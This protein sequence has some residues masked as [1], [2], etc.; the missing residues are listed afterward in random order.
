M[1]VGTSAVP[2]RGLTLG[3]ANGHSPSA[4]PAIVSIGSTHAVFR[5][6]VIAGPEAEVPL[7]DAS[8]TV[9]RVNVIQPAKTTGRAY[10]S[11]CVFIESVADVIPGSVLPPTEDN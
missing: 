9:V 4:E 10:G 7:G 3:I 8:L 6:V 2:S 1:N 11:S 5:L